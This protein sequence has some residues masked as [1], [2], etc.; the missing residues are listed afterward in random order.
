MSTSPENQP[1]E[2]RVQSPEDTMA[3]MTGV[4]R[5]AEESQADRESLELERQQEAQRRAGITPGQPQTPP[6]Q[7]TTRQREKA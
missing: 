1:T 2:K 5:T 3:R 7:P 6:Q 4:P